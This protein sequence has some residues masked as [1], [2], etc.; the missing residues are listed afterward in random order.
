MGLKDALRFPP[1][2]LPMFCAIFFLK[3]VA[4]FKINRMYNEMLKST[5]GML[6]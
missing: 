1:P 6:E 2:P 3:I 5:Y 4:L